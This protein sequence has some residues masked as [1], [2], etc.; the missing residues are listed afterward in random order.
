[1]HFFKK[2]RFA[3]AMAVALPM[4]SLP[5]SQTHAQSPQSPAPQE[6]ADLPASAGTLPTVM[7]HG[8]S[9]TQ[10]PQPHDLGRSVVQTRRASISDTAKLLL[11]VPGAN[12]NGAGGVSGLPS[13][14]GLADDRLRVKVDGMD[15]IASC[16]NHMNPA[17]SYIAPSQ[18]GSLTVFAGISPV[19]AGG[20]SIGGSVL[21]ESA[22]P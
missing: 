5:F 14:R 16:P 20:D 21:A 8:Q 12:V 17:L 4:L 10:L 22:V 7:I 9:E 6:R 13:L 18:L 11:E 1:M 2:N 3:Q 15:L 19:S